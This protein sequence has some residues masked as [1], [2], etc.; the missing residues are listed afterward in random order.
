[1]K[2][3]TEDLTIIMT[4]I[5]KTIDELKASHNKQDKNT[6]KFSSTNLEQLNKALNILKEINK[7]L[8][9]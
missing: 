4:S 3:T 5:G 7:Q 6:N 9:L 1:M 2:Y 8:E